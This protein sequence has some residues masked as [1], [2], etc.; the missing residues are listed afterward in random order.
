M[1]VFVAGATGAIGRPLVHQLIEAGHEVSAITRSEDRAARLREAGVNAFVGDALDRGL[2]S[3]IV[4]QTRPECLVHQLTTFPTTMRPIRTLRDWRRT[5]RLRVEGTRSFVDL[6][7]SR[8]VRRVVAQSIAFSYRPMTQPRRATED[9]PVYGDGHRAMD[10]F[11]RHLSK[12]EDIVT[13]TEGVEGVA[14]RYGGWYGPGTFFERGGLMQEL[15]TKR[16]LPLVTGDQ[17]SWNAIHVDDAAS[18]TVA[19]LSGP[20]GIYNIV[21]D[22]PKRWN[23][24]VATFCGAIGAPRPRVVPRW[25]MAIAGFYLR[26]LVLHQAPVSNDKAK[27][28]LDWKL[29]YPTMDR[30]FEAW[31]D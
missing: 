13:T 18:G 20:P 11:M 26:H 10:L 14:L 8:G 5:V 22:R 17:G 21:D 3:R 15:A 9:D 4:E 7:R 1:K 28:L 29:S 31:G 12:V 23:E 30:G 27:T 24:F 6:A 2:L 25:S 19:A 16:R